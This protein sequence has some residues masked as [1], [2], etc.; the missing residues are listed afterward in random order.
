[1]EQVLKIAIQSKQIAAE[2]YEQFA[3][4]PI[5]NL[6]IWE[7]FTRLDNQGLILI[8]GKGCLTYG[9]RK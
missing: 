4:E 5:T 2:Y 7:E 1:M 6:A 8:S 9:A 3:T